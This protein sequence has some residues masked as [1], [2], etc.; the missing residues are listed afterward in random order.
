M[1]TTRGIPAPPNHPDAKTRAFFQAIY[2]NME[3]LLGRRG[4][5]GEK[6][7]TVDDVRL[8]GLIGVDKAR[9]II[10]DSNAVDPLLTIQD[11]RGVVGTGTVTDITGAAYTDIA[12]VP[13]VIEHT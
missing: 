7:L 13:Y 5:F 6:A 9:K 10:F 11:D 4:D 12:G 3:V 8:T 2:E 1:S